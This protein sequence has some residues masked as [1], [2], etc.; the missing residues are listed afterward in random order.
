MYM[1]LLFSATFMRLFLTFF[2]SGTSICLWATGGGG[3]GRGKEERQ[4]CRPQQQR[5]VPLMAGGGR[6]SQDVML[7]V[8]LSNSHRH[9]SDRTVGGRCTEQH[10]ILKM[11]DLTANIYYTEWVV[12]PN[13]TIPCPSRS[14]DNASQCDH[15][16]DKN[17]DINNLGTKELDKGFIHKS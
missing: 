7:D 10:C 8:K 12:P 1:S 11:C 2:L 9:T 17:T 14:F 13:A 16:R 4:I 5:N 15:F 3:G 6:K